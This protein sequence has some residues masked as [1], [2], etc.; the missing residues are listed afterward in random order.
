MSPENDNNLQPSNLESA[1]PES[2][3]DAP[4]SQA[5]RTSGAD[6][7]STSGAAAVAVAVA[8][9]KDAVEAPPESHLSDED[10]CRDRD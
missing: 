2:S 10:A 7:Q 8:R 1:T 6:A 4:L 9:E 5:E 3:A